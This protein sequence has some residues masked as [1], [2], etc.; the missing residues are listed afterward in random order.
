M[1]RIHIL[2]MLVK[3]RCKILRPFN[4]GL[5]HLM[6]VWSW[7]WHPVAMSIKTARNAP[8]KEKTYKINVLHTII[9]N[10]LCFK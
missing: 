7:T 9:Q 8:L 10:F 3:S 5:T 4:T 6:L 2:P 1:W